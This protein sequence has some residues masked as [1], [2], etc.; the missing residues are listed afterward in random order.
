MRQASGS[1]VDLVVESSD[2]PDP[3]R[4]AG[5]DGWAFQSGILHIVLEVPRACRVLYNH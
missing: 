2:R 1:G 5:S 4:N 3:S